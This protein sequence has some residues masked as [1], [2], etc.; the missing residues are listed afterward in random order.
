MPVKCQESVSGCGDSLVALWEL[1]RKTT[2]FFLTQGPE[3]VQLAHDRQGLCKD[4]YVLGADPAYVQVGFFEH[5]FWGGDV[6]VALESRDDLSVFLAPGH[7][8]PVLSRQ[9]RV[10]PH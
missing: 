7:R 3:G 2:A 9:Q 6:S 10:C 1:S 8:S 5:A 4:R